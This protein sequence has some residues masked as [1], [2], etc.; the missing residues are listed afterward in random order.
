[1]TTPRTAMFEHV[2]GPHDGVLMPVEVDESGVP[3]ER[4]LFNSM[5]DADFSRNPLTTIVADS[6]TTFYERDVRIG[7]DGVRYV[8]VFR[9]EDVQRNDVP[10]AA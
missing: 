9:G 8:F 10:R 6:T 2:N 7:E 1:M 4:Y 5:T 3:V